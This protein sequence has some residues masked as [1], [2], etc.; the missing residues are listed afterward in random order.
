MTRRVDYRH[1][2][3][4]AFVVASLTCAVVVFG[5]A[6]FRL[7]EGFRDVATSAVYYFEFLFNGESTVDA[8]VTDFS[9]LPLKLPFGLPD[10]WEEFRVR[11]AVYWTLVG[12]VDNIG[13]YIAQLSDVLVLLCYIALYILPV[14]CVGFLIAT[15]GSKETNN[16]YN[17][18]S[19]SLTRW[20]WICRHIFTPVKNWFVGFVAFVKQHKVYVRILVVV[21]MYNFNIFTIALEAVA[22]YLYFVA[23]FDFVSLYVQALKLLVDLLAAL[24]FVPTTVWVVVALVVLDVVRK[25]I[26]YARLNRFERRNRGF[27]N[28]RP[29]L[30]LVCGTMGK[31]KTT[32]I[33]DMALSQEI[34]FR[35]KAFEKLLQADLKFPYFPWMTF[36][37]QLKTAIARHKVYN[38]ATCK[39]FVSTVGSYFKAGFDGGS[40]IAKSCR[41]QLKKRYG[42][43]CSDL[44]FGYDYGR[45]G[46]EYNDGLQ[47]VDVWKVLTDYAQLY[48]IY[49]MTGS[50]IVSNY[51]IRTDNVLEDVGNFPLW[52]EELF[53]RDPRLMDAYSRHSRILDFD[54]LRLGR[55]VVEDNM[56]SNA[57]EFGVVLVTEIG[58][59]RGN[60]LELQDKKKNS[61]ETNQKNDLFNSWLKMCRHSA[62]VD[63]FPFIKI[64]SDEQRPSSWG[65][66]AVELCEIVS[67]RD[68]GETRLA[69]PFFSLGGLVSDWEVDKFKQ[70]YID[71]RFRRGDNTLPM[72]LFKG[73][74]ARINDYKTRIYNTFGYSKMNIEVEAGTRDGSYLERNYYLMY[75][76]IY[77]RRF[78]TDCYSDFY[79]QKALKSLVGLED[80]PEYADVRATVQEFLRQN[81]YF[82]ADLLIGLLGQKRP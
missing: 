32:M 47:V 37:N 29:I 75:K 31:K 80:L 55:K 40:V 67:I 44:I 6:V 53:K 9:A 41:R 81:S 74:S 63:N 68:S 10:T 60:M 34:M 21:W 73:L 69:M 46:Y 76:K 22:Y 33:T 5:N 45:Y 8:T 82:M 62:T 79:M 36:E 13:A 50:L 2:I 48:F 25:R 54:M 23:S 65:A 1:F 26:G 61:D 35:D 64:I 15:F 20:K 51:G 56:Y 57:F 42:Y 71:Y 30:T 11:W 4:A 27:I 38:L 78:A 14:V 70:A 19:K 49:V 12:N 17:K 43:A 59:E 52:N 24:D 3:C 72:Y 18:D 77:S 7:G 16:D 58:K 66:D 28:E 39:Q